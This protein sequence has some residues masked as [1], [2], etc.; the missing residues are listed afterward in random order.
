[1]FFRHPQASE[2]VPK[3]RYRSTKLERAKRTLWA[4]IEHDRWVLGGE[5]GAG[6]RVSAA[7]SVLEFVRWMCF[8]RH[9]QASEVAPKVRYRFTK[10]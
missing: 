1:M 5:Q 3:V 8:V 6:P 4:V 2:V 9:P 10:Y 7:G